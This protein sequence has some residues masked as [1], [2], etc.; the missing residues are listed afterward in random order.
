MTLNNKIKG[1]LSGIFAAVTYGV[2]P[3]ALLLYAMGISVDTVLFHRFAIAALLL[4]VWMIARRE[5]FSLTRRE[6]TVLTGLGILFSF[7]SLTLFT[8]FNYM[9]VG[10]A[11]TLLFI[12]PVMVAAIMAFFFH[13]RI[14]LSVIFSILLALAGVA[15]LCQ[16][17][18][19]GTVSTLGVILVLLSSLAYAI[20]MVVVQTVRISMSTIKMTFYVVVVCAVVV[21]LHSIA[22]PAAQITPITSAPAFAIAFGLAFIPTVLSIYLANISLQMIG[23]T[24]TAILGALEPLTAVMIGAILYGE[25]ITAQLLTG[26]SLI[27]CAVMFSILGKKLHIPALKLRSGNK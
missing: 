23:S 22:S 19:G 21:F 6:F 2:N 26:I 14:T 12:Y 11:S 7:S 16:P 5:S 9:D 1:T 24:K 27:L 17:G 3:L 20:Y 13:E 18:P 8:A 10:I 15:L 4:G 25:T